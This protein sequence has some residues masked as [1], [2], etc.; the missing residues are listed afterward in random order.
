MEY[1]VTKD[2]RTE[3]PNPILLTQGEKVI[4]GK[5]TSANFPDWVFCIKSDNSNKGWVP[6]QIIKY[7]NNYGIITEDYSANELNI[8][9]G[10]IVNGTKEING[11]VWVE[12]TETNDIGWIPRN[13][14]KE[15]Q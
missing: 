10:A 12:N 15:I 1:I 2:H 11:C 5:K 9:R 6:H 4:I 7:E 3:F 14:L 8:D 13:K